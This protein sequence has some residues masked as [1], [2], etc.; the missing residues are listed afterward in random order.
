MENR[1]NYE[2]FA[3]LLGKWAEKF[4]P[5]VESEAFY[6]IYQ[7]LKT[8]SQTET[9]LPTSDLTFRAFQQSDPNQIKVVWYLMDPYPRRYKDQ[10]PQATG[11]ALD[12]SNSPDKKLQPSLIKFY[13]ALSRE[14]EEKVDYSPSLQYLLDQGNLMLNTD[15]TV[16]LGKTASHERLW[17]PFQKFFLEEVMGTQSGIIYVL[18]GKPSHRLERYIMPLSNYIFKLEHPAAA[19]YSA[20][21]WKSEGIF[22]K[23]NHILHNNNGKN[24]H[25]FWNKR[26]WE[27]PVPF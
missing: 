7:T 5:F 11:I 22:K 20:R 3:P 17:E 12:C 13:D 19:D 1:M 14:L 15:L 25:I 24:T 9:I 10:T 4:R 23:I 16:K 6:N 21:D 2:N 8:D 18:C 26:E 27:A